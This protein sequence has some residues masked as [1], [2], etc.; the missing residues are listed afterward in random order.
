[1]IIYYICMIIWC[2][3]YIDNKNIN[4]HHVGDK[5]IIW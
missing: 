3:W 4:I 2:V 1:M 5:L